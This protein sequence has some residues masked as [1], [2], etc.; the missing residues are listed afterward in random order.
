[1]FDIREYFAYESVAIIDT[2]K[3]GEWWI[4]QD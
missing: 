3:N 1:M 2:R 4:G